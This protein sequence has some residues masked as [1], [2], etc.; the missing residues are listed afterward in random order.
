[1]AIRIASDR[2]TAEISQDGAELQ[3]LTDASGRDYLWDGDPAYWAGRAPILFPIVG[4]LNGDRFHWQ[5]RDYSLP[6]HGFARRRRFAIVE[7]RGDCVVLRL[8]SDAATRAAWP[9][10]FC[11]DMIFAISG[12]TLT[13]TARVA[14]RGGDP[15]PASFGFHPAL[16]WPLPGASSKAGHFVQ[17]DKPEL[18]AIRR[19]DAEGLLDPRPRP[20]TVDGRLLALDDSLFAEDAMIFD[21]LESRSLVYQGPGS[22]PVAIEFQDMPHLGL[23]M[24]P[25]AG[26]LCIEPWQGHSDP[27]GFDGTL[28]EKPGMVTIAPGTSRSFTTAIRIG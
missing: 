14:N 17:F 18:A 28:G 25:G 15:M 8:E 27:A 11:L 5:G 6:R 26:Y 3:R 2:L 4:M 7:E 12:A 10:D 13:M 20:T 22:A 1:M 9:F 19:L 16:R 23:W 24:K 21:Q